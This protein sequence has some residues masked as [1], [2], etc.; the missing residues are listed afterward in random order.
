MI[1]RSDII[2]I[3]DVIN[4]ENGEFKKESWTYK[5]KVTVRIKENIKGISGQDIVIMSDVN[6]ICARTKYDYGRYVFFLRQFDTVY[7]IS[8]WQRGAVKIDNEKLK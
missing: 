4:I 7:K 2:V 1:D 5:Q 3:D 8:N 6:F